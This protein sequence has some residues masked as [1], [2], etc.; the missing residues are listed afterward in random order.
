MINLEVTEKL[1]TALRNS[2]AV[3]LLGSRQAGKTTLAS[4]I[5]KS[6]IKKPILYIRPRTGF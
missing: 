3:A 4:E 1:V 2:P 5:V 6:V